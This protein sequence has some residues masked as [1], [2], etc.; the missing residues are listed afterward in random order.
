MREFKNVSEN[1]FS[2]SF[3]PWQSVEKGRTWKA[4]R[5]KRRGQSHQEEQRME[6]RG[7]NVR[8]CPR[9]HS[10]LA[11]RHRVVDRAAAAIFSCTV[12]QVKSV[13]RG[14]LLQGPEDVSP[15]TLEQPG[16]GSGP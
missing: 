13:P 3:S 2:C 4:G 11:I 8:L 1:L 7:T 12:T 5:G 9:A 14:Q 16:Q 10:V 15:P 6:G